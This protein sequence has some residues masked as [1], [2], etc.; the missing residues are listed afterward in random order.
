MQK[1]H[2]IQLFLGF[3]GWFGQPCGHTE[4]H[5]AQHPD[6]DGHHLVQHRVQQSRR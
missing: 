4:Q 5:R 3:W 1:K 2:I 6:R